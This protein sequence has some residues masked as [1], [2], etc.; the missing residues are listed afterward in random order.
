MSHADTPT[1]TNAPRRRVSTILAFLGILSVLG[2]C[3]FCGTSLFVVK[4]PLA[5]VLGGYKM[6]M[7]P[8]SST[9]R[10]PDPDDTPSFG[11]GWDC[12][13]N[14]YRPVQTFAT[15]AEMAISFYRCPELEDFP[16]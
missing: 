5:F 11:I 1:R 10:W 7:H 9:T 8:N 15:P 12:G 13:H 4:E 6:I 16:R 2:P 14:S 3:A